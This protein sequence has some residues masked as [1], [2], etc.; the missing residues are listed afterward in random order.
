MKW[1][2]RKQERNKEQESVLSYVE[3]TEEVKMFAE[4]HRSLLAYQSDSGL[5]FDS[6]SQSDNVTI[7]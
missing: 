6:W 5:F 2:I 1:D 7:A 3:F 4:W